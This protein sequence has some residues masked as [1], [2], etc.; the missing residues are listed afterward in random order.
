MKTKAAVAYRAGE[1]LVVE[2]VDLE[3]CVKLELG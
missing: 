1:P 3:L 2:E